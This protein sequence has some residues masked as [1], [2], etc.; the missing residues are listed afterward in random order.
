MSGVY[1]SPGR[2]LVACSPYGFAVSD[3]DRRWQQAL[4]DF[5]VAVRRDAL[6]RLTLAKLLFVDAL[7]VALR[8]VAPADLPRVLA[9]ALP[10]RQAK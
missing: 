7:P 4:D 5:C 8:T 6:R 2:A 1:T 9:R 3:A 10:R